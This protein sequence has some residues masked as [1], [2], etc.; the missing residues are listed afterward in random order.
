MIW[1]AIRR[2]SLAYIVG[3]GILLVFIAAPLIFELAPSRTAAGQI[4]G[5]IINRH[6]L[7]ALIL[8]AIALISLFP[9]GKNSVPHSRGLLIALLGTMIVI[10][11]FSYSIVR[12]ILN[13]LIAQIGDFDLTPKDN[14]LRKRFGMWHGIS[15]L[16]ALITLILGVLAV[17]LECRTNQPKEPAD[18]ESA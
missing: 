16:E 10:E 6:S 3:G 13:D 14:P 11:L 5:A 2:L 7:L 1:T 8:T 15:S 17:G 12:P 4:A 18:H 9:Q